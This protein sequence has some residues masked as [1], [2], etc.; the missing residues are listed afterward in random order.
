L[1]NKRQS[2]ENDTRSECPVNCPGQEICDNPSASFQAQKAN[3]YSEG[4]VIL[5]QKWRN[6][7]ALKDDY[8]EM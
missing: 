1:N 8:N 7:V 6:D 2:T 5:E 3:F 4:N